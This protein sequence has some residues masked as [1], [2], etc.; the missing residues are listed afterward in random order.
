MAGPCWPWPWRRQTI[1]CRGLLGDILR[2]S[3]CPDNCSSNG[4]RRNTCNRLLSWKA[5][6]AHDT[7]CIWAL[8]CP[9][10][11]DRMAIWTPTMIR[12]SLPQSRHPVMDAGFTLIELLVVL[13]ILALLAAFAAPQVTGY[14]GR[15]RTESARVQIS[16]IASALE[17]YAIDNS[18]YPT[19]E[20]GLRA[21]IEAPSGSTRWAGPYLK[22]ADGLKDPWGRPYQYA[23]QAPNGFQVFSLGSDNARGGTGEAQDVTN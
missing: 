18:S 13:G 2:A 17:L 22:R 16:A 12:I 14:L 9:R 11:V 3:I 10:F 5:A 15:A 19:S 8:S 23:W 20:Q 6:F 4:P 1:F 21:L 7:H